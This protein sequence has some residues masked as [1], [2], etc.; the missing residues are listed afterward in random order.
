MLELNYP[1]L[2]EVKH[3]FIYPVDIARYLK[4][5]AITEECIS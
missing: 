5:V 4:W 1:E 2:K 3:F